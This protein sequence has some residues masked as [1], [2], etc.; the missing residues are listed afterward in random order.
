M[1]YRICRIVLLSIYDIGE[2]NFGFVLFWIVF[3]FSQKSLYLVRI[4]AFR[5]ESAGDLCEERME[6]VKQGVRANPST[7]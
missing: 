1:F 7:Y 2:L 3:N 5:D 6:T 4:I